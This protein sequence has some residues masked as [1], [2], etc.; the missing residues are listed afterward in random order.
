MRY[1]EIDKNAQFKKKV[2]VLMEV[3]E[4]SNFIHENDL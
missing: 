2:I 4:N 3:Q 1:K